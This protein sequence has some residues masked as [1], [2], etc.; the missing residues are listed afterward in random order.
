MSTPTPNRE[1]VVL[2]LYLL[3]GESGSVHTEDIAVKCHQHFPDAFSWTKFRQFPD[4]D[5]VRVALTDARKEKNGALVQGRAGQSHGLVAKT[6]REPTP[7]GWCLT[8][9]GVLWIRSRQ[10]D[11]ERLLG[12]PETKEHRQRL[13]QQLRRV[14]E[15]T[16]FG[17]FVADPEGFR[18]GIGQIADLMQCRVDSEPRVWESRFTTLRN[19]AIAAKQQ[20]I[21]QFVDKCE[22]EYR[23]QR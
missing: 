6:S 7:D 5:I 22:S 19:K 4:K 2:V 16:L 23:A 15:H 10:A 1:L 12:K 3:G 14:R 18:A 20:D 13:L 21:I 17:T 11:L 8:P 9:R